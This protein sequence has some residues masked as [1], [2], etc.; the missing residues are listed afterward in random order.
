[1]VTASRGSRV[2]RGRWLRYRHHRHSASPWISPPP[3]GRPGRATPAA[4]YP[5]LGYWQ[6]WGCASP[7]EKSIYSEEYR[8]LCAV[9]RELRLAA[10]LTQVQVAARLEVPQS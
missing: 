2:R 5:M 6:G 1:M 10:G 3:A 8:R 4:E 7:V 9:L